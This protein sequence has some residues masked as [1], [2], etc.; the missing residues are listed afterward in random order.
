MS[1]KGRGAKE[2]PKP[3]AGSQG[4]QTLKIPTNIP[5]LYTKWEN[6]YLEMLMI[7]GIVVYFLNFFTGKT[8]TRR[9]LLHG[10]IVTNQ[11]WKAIFLSSVMMG[12][13]ILMML[14]HLCRKNLNI[15]LPCGAR[16][17][18]VV[19]ECWSSLNYSKDK[20]LLQ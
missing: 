13:R 9:L 17:E 19:K 1:T 7:A 20:I 11:S 5:M 15:Y 18:F 3:K 10:S 16:V 2:K 12:P 8:K 14:K 4:P 6:Y